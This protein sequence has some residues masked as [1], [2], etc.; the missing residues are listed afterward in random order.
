[1]NPK[2][3][4]HKKKRINCE[5]YALKQYL[6]A[7]CIPVGTKLEPFAGGFEAYE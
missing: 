1:M 7:F 6:F 4:V 5:I 2:K 3:S